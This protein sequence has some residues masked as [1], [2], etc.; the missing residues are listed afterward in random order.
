[1]L[2]I[3]NVQRG[4]DPSMKPQNML[5]LFKSQSNK[6]TLILKNCYSSG[7]SGYLHWQLEL[8]ITLSQG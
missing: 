1:M 2:Q 5:T 4:N 8:N 3:P 7:A 6:Q